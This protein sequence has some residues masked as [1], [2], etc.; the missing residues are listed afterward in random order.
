LGSD[1]NTSYLE[2]YGAT[3]GD[4]LF[5]PGPE[6]LKKAF[7]AM[8]ELLVKE[9]CLE[10][11]SPAG[12]ADGSPRELSLTMTTTGQTTD[13]SRARYVS[14]GLLPNVHGSHGSYFLA[15]LGLLLAPRAFAWLTFVWHVGRF[16]AT[17]LTRLKPGSPHV[18]KRDPND[19]P[20]GRPFEVGDLVIVC[21]KCNSAHHVRSWRMNRCHCMREYQGCGCYCYLRRAPRWLR[22][23]LDFLSGARRSE[24]GRR[25]LCRCAGDNDGY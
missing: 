22:K 18:N 6:D 14:P 5:S 15:L 11:A 23:A 10:Y 25:W 8:E 16:R 2:K 3:G 13:C 4:Y 7:H 19:G 17:H 24:A 20:G 9:I 1:V 12:E 21:P